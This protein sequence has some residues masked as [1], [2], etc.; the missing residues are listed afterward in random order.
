[1]ITGTDDED[2]L[3]NLAVVLDR[4][5]SHGIKLK[6]AKC[7]F[8]AEAVEY[9]GHKVDVN[10]IHTSNRK[11]EAIQKAPYPR[12]A[13]QL[14]SFLGL[15]HYYGKFILTH[16]NFILTCHLFCNH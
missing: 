2:H 10:G 14:K 7:K 11:V 4:L 13:Q 16:P 8:L 12:N 5:E 15:V 6:K 1:M 3:K 9:L